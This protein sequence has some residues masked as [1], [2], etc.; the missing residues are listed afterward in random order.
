V[1]DI[2]SATEEANHTVLH[3]HGEEL[4]D[5]L[6]GRPHQHLTLS[7]PLGIHDVV[8][9]VVQNAHENHLDR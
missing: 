9:S 8:Q 2:S 3:H 4:D 7:T 6:R 1:S 5:N